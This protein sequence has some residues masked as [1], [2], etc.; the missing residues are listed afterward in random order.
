MF[1]AARDKN[2]MNNYLK[3]LKDMSETTNQ[4][5]IVAGNA[6]QVLKRKTSFVEH[7][8]FSANTH[9]RIV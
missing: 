9:T 4:R 3:L 6:T 5:L 7:T 2:C 8:M 1:S